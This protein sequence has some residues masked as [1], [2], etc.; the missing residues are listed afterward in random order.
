[1]SGPKDAATLAAGP[2]FDMLADVR[3]EITLAMKE[4]EPFA[5]IDAAREPPEAEL[6]EVA[7]RLLKAVE[8]MKP[9]CGLLGDRFARAD[10][11]PARETAARMVH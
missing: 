1:M 3:N 2:L 11:G 7:E 4:V 5:E 6:R 10:A 9:A 8:R